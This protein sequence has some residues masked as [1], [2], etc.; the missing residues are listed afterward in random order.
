[1]RRYRDRARRSGQ[2]RAGALRLEHQHRAPAGR[3]ERA[4]RAP[5]LRRPEP[6]LHVLLRAAADVR[7]QVTGGEPAQGLRLR[8]RTRGRGDGADVHGQHPDPALEARNAGRRPRSGTVALARFPLHS[9]EDPPVRRRPGGSRGSAGR[10]LRGAARRRAGEDHAMSVHANQIVMLAQAISLLQPLDRPADAVLRS[11]FRSHAE[12]GQRDRAFIA[13]SVFA[14]L[15]RK[16]SIESFA[17]STGPRKRALAVLNRGLGRS[18]RELDGALHASER[19]WL[20]QR[21]AGHAAL[22]AAEEANVPD[23]LWQRLGEFLA[24]PERQALVRAWQ[25]PAPLDLRVNA[26]A[27]RRE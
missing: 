16:R 6:L 5:G 25:R 2:A 21:K 1:A 12:L 24:E 17:A 23:W 11:F 20:A 7:A 8:V 4:A 3:Q 26:R 22:S 13:E 14:W 9:G 15:R 19:E 18:L 27:A 10:H